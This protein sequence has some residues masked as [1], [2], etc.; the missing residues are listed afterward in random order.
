MTLEA[1]SFSA[2][3]GGGVADEWE[4]VATL[5]A[6]LS[7]TRGFEESRGGKPEAQ[8]GHK[9]LIRYRADLVPTMRLREGTRIFEIQ[10]IRDVDER[11]AYQE[12]RCTERRVS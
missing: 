2:D 7:P 3:G 11:G 10:T 1:L 8:M 6:A 5:W 4:E 9:V 12:V